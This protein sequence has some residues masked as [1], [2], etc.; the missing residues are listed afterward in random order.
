MGFL[1]RISESPQERNLRLRQKHQNIQFQ[2]LQGE[3]IKVLPQVKS[4]ALNLLA[5]SSANDSDWLSTTRALAE[6]KKVSVA[7]NSL[8]DISIACKAHSLAY[9][10]EL[11][12][13][14]KTHPSLT[15]YSNLTSHWWQIFENLK[16]LYVVGRY[17]N[18]DPQS[19]F[20]VLEVLKQIDEFIIS[21]FGESKEIL[22]WR[23]HR[24]LL[25]GEFPALVK[26]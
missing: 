20:D 5:E 15:T 11:L 21:Q 3:N 23:S 14:P 2:K 10:K 6:Y 16:D 1:K 22:D 17:V 25:L 4:L 7:A 9:M 26:I 24:E 8:E 19:V 12:A 18:L 13:L